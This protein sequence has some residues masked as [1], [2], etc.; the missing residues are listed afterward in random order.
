MPCPDRPKRSLMGMLTGTS[1]H[2]T[3]EP[4]PVRR[5]LS[6]KTT[7]P[8][9]GDVRGQAQESQISER[10]P[11]VDSLQ[12]SVC[13]RCLGTMGAFDGLCCTRCNTLVHGCCTYPALQVGA[14]KAS[15]TSGWTCDYCLQEQA[16]LENAVPGHYDF[17]AECGQGVIPC[18]VSARE[19]LRCASCRASC[20]PCCF[21]AGAERG[22]W[23]CRDCSSLPRYSRVTLTGWSLEVSLAK[24]GRL[25]PLVRGTLNEDGPRNGAHW[26]TSEIV[27]A[28]TG[29]TLVT[30][31]RS[32]VE[33]RGFMSKRLARRVNLPSH[34][35]KLFKLGFPD[36]WLPLVRYC[37]R[38]F[39]SALEVAVVARSRMHSM[40]LLGDGTDGTACSNMPHSSKRLVAS[41]QVTT[42]EA[43][44]MFAEAS[45]VISAVSGLSL[46]IGCQIKRQFADA[47]FAG[48]LAAHCANS[49]G[50]PCILIAYDDGPWELL[51]VTQVCELHQQKKIVSSE[52]VRHSRKAIHADT[53]RRKSPVPDNRGQQSIG[54]YCRPSNDAAQVVLSAVTT[55]EDSSA[56]TPTHT[57]ELKKALSACRPSASDF[58]EQV[59][60]RVGRDPEQCRVNAFA[61]GRPQD[62]KVIR[63]VRKETPKEVKP[64]ETLG[65]VPKS[66]GPRRAQKVRTF[67]NGRSFFDGRDFLQVT[68]PTLDGAFTDPPDV[69]TTADSEEPS[70]PPSPTSLAYLSSLHTGLTPQRH[71]QGWGRRTTFTTPFRPVDEEGNL[72]S[73]DDLDDAG[74]QPTNLDK[75]ICDTR[76]RRG[77]LDRKLRTRGLSPC[78][79]F[80]R[81][82]LRKAPALF[83]KLDAAA[84]A[85]RDSDS[86]GVDTEDEMDMA[87]VAM[88]P[89]SIL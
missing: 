40:P 35:I 76:A 88:I 16:L 81:A 17:C 27:Y 75:F 65:D 12:G 78:L 39:P 73:D 54:R 2:E 63:P 24:D 42:S 69:S 38:G 29:T 66:D 21:G 64:Q 67:L 85:P 15:R 57:A 8:R 4:C 44:A 26:R 10:T 72:P 36:I 43:V 13:S 20:H 33:L 55:V 52:F 14:C 74:W 60:A 47:W 49:S 71:A 68:V 32:V 50:M 18:S 45:P 5:R 51:P 23:T 22:R 61:E 41:P 48:R 82:D 19:L 37:L 62:T 6:T 9:E 56:W 25:I 77:R 80:S 46:E 7:Q 87:P 89:A 34:L 83:Q 1:T 31:T 59:A 79:R 53:K 70:E 28:V 58:W 3:E 11:D 86:S 30:R 84:K